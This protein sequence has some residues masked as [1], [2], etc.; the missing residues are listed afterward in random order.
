MGK[1]MR[2]VDLIITSMENSPE[3]WNVY[4]N[5]WFTNEPLENYS[6]GYIRN[7]DHVS[8]WVPNGLFFY[9]TEGRYGNLFRGIIDRLKFHL[10]FKR[11]QQTQA[12]LSILG[13]NK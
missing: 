2:A 7:Q 10:A 8:I 1:R 12:S 9:K 11:W 13:M 3:K 4:N 6:Q 5:V